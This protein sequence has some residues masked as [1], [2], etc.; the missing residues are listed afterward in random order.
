MKFSFPIISS[1][2]GTSQ[3]MIV[4]QSNLVKRWRLKGRGR[5]SGEGGGRQGTLLYDEDAIFDQ[6]VDWQPFC[7]VGI[8]RVEG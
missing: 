1:R 3:S 2:D 4:T 6:D 7:S 5:S 8:E